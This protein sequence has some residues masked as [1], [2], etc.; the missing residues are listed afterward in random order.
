MEQ[1]LSPLFESLPVFALPLVGPLQG[2]LVPLPF[3]CAQ[4]HTT[5]LAAPSFTGPSLLSAAASCV[6]ALGCSATSVD[7][8][9]HRRS[10]TTSLSSSEGLSGN[11]DD[12][13]SC[14]A[15]VWDDVQH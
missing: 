4:R 2:L 14:T 11:K 15:W 6:F 1:T 13:C 7:P 3:L 8:S 9:V 12:T 10:S 5:A